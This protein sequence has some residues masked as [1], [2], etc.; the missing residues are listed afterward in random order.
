MRVDG[1]GSLCVNTEW[2]GVSLVPRTVLCAGDRVLCTSLPGDEELPFP[3]PAVP[4]RPKPTA[5]RGRGRALAGS[6]DRRE[7]N[8]GRDR[9]AG[10]SRR[11]SLPC[12]LLGWRGGAFS[13][14]SPTPPL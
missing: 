3:L 9:T 2:T 6:G 5:S 13:P 11:F 12:N 4:K 10:S 8:V 14:P 7:G 1:R